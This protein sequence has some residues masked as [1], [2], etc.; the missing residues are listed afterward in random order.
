MV[1]DSADTL[2]PSL[3]TAESG[4][5]LSR[6]SLN[7]VKLRTRPNSPLWKTCSQICLRL[8]ASHTHTHTHTHMHMA[9]LTAF[10]SE[11]FFS[12]SSNKLPNVGKTSASLTRSS[13]PWSG[14]HTHGF[15]R[16][17]FSR[18]RLPEHGPINTFLL[19]SRSRLVITSVIIDLSSWQP[20]G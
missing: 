8:Q 14:N 16:L 11:R 20:L 19:A 4:A 5:S 10:H 7:T 13:Q 12:M 15:F 9:L 3:S 18:E 1:P 2:I 17:L 6:L